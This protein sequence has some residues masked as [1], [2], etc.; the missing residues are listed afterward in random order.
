MAPA[1]CGETLK[2]PGSF[3]STSVP[4]FSS[5]IERDLAV[6]LWRAARARAFEPLGH[7]LDRGLAAQKDAQ[8][9]GEL[10]GGLV[11]RL[12]HPD[13]RA[14]VVALHL[15]G[16]RQQDRGA[17]LEQIAK[18]R[19]PLGEQHRLVMAGRVGEP[20]D[21]HLAAGAGAPLGARHHRA[22]DAACVRAGAHGAGELGPGLHPHALERRGV[23]VERMPGEE[24][25][26]GIEL[27]LQ[28]L[29]RQPRLDIAERQRR[30]ARTP[31]EQ[32]GLPDRR[33]VELALRRR[34]DSIDG[35]EHARAIAV[36]RIEGAGGGEA[37]QHALVDRTRIDAAREIGKI[38]E[39]LF[40]ARLDDRLDRLPADALEGRQRV[41]DG[42]AR[43][44]RRRRRSG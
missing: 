43:R 11:E 38:G 13:A 15:G 24:E 9:L 29:G 28:P 27:L 12:D 39:R 2:R 37:F 22:R 42:V 36:Q 30:A 17:R 23:V 10:G 14:H 21:P 18:L 26:D 5:N 1:I 34:H 35:R 19:Q 25:A 4:S 8:S 16:E 33:V 6:V 31:A 20:D 44:P 32:L 40:A 3:T 7:A 41:V